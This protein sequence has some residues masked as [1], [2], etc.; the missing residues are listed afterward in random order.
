VITLESNT[1]GIFAANVYIKGIPT[2]ISV[3]D[4]L[5]VNKTTGKL[6]F[7]QQSV[8]GSVWAALFE[9]IWAKVNANYETIDFQN[10]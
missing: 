6:V 2:T 3:D 1:A 9:K 4:Y 7:A 5:P 10:L 8:T